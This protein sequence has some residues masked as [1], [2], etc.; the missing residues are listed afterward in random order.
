MKLCVASVALSNMHPKVALGLSSN[1]FYLGKHKPDLEVVQMLP[2][3][4]EIATARNVCIEYALE[5]ECD[6]FFWLDDDTILLTPEVLKTL[7]ETMER[8][9]EIYMLAPAYYV[10]SYPY[11]QMAFKPKDSNTMAMLEVG[12]ARELMDE[13]GVVSGLSAIGN[14][15]TLMN[16]EVFKRLTISRANKEWYRTGKYHTEDTYFCAKVKSVI[17]QFMCGIDM[18]VTAAHIIGNDWVDKENVRYKRLK[19]KLVHALKQDEGL[20]DKLELL[21]GEPRTDGPYPVEID[22]SLGRM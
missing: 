13:E 4:F 12:E 21:V 7:I 8:R 22:A 17:P 3:R 10:R 15:C 18:N 5:R 20:L 16:M 1:M 11:R 9:P 6:L 19:Y 2:E 14:G